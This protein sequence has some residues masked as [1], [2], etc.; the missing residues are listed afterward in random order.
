MFAILS[1]IHANL[2]ALQAVLADISQFPVEA[3]YCLGDVIGYGPDPIE[4]LQIAQRWPVVL[5]GDHENFILAEESNEGFTSPMIRQNLVATRAKIKS[6]PRG[7][8]LW[9]FLAQCPARFESGDTLFVHGSPRQ[10]THEYLFPEDIYSL[11]RLNANAELFRRICFCGHT[12]LPG[13]FH[14]PVPA[15]AWQYLT[16][17][18]CQNRFPI[19]PGSDEKLIFN[20]GSVGLPRDKDPRTSYVLCSPHEVHF[21][22]LEYDIERTVAKVLKMPDGE[23]LAMRLREGR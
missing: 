10:A 11:T 22:R 5:R 4:C 19:S 20:V 21:R 1:D 16:P 9:V 15:A 18:E 8:D 13:V 6:H 12:H 3:I 7:A 17:A 23:F 2:A 14:R